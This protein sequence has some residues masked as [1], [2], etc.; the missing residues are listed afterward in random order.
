MRL[1]TAGGQPVCIVLH[2]S[3]GEIFNGISEH[4][5][6]NN[7]LQGMALCLLPFAALLPRMYH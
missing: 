3:C 1:G 6:F 2:R 5:A 7:K 4:T